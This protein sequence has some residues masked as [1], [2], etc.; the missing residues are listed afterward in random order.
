MDLLHS[1][2]QRHSGAHSEPLAVHAAMQMLLSRAVDYW[3]A[4]DIA[5]NGVIRPPSGRQD[6][7]FYAGSCRRW[8]G[9]GKAIFAAV[10]LHPMVEKKQET[11]GD[12]YATP[13]DTGG[14]RRYSLL[15]SKEIS[16]VLLSCRCGVPE[17][18]DYLAAFLG[19][20]FSSP[21]KYLDGDTSPEFI[22]AETSDPA[23]NGL[24][25]A[26]SAVREGRPDSLSWTVEVILRPSNDTLSLQEGE[27]SGWLDRILLLEVSLERIFNE[28][29]NLQHKLDVR[30]SPIPLT[31]DEASARTR[32]NEAQLHYK[33]ALDWSKE[34]QAAAWER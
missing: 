20:G 25:K 12:A 23:E 22:P 29:A 10:T 18:R 8:L 3:G 34:R 7:F 28:Y 15:S 6:L 33:H 31:Y 4:N 30:T 19:C 1:W 26:F 16:A 17:Y 5:Q 32:L 24:V 9:E 2:C 13:F 14:L 11:C 27:A 21:E